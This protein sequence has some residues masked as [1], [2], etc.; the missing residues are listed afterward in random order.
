MSSVRPAQTPRA[1]RG[2]PL[3]GD[4]C[5]GNESLFPP[6]SSDLASH[7]TTAAPLV[8]SVAAASLPLSPP[9]SFLPPPL[10]ALCMFSVVQAHALWP[11][12]S[13]WST[14]GCAHPVLTRLHAGLEVLCM[15]GFVTVAGLQDLGPAT[16]PGGGSAAAWDRRARGHVA[17]ACKLALA[18]ALAS[19]AADAVAAAYA[20]GGTDCTGSSMGK[21]LW[22]LPFLAA[23]RLLQ[24]LAC[25]LRLD[26]AQTA[27]AWALAHVLLWGRPAL[28]PPLGTLDYLLDDCKLR[29]YGLFYFSLAPA[30]HAAGLPSA[31]DRPRRRAAALALG[32]A[33]L[34]AIP[35]LAPRWFDDGFQVLSEPRVPLGL[36]A[37]QAAAAALLVALALEAS[38]RRPSPVSRVL[39]AGTFS[40]FLLH[41][42]LRPIWLSALK[43]SL[44]ALHAALPSCAAP[45][46]LGGL[47]PAA[48]L[49]SAHLGLLLAVQ[50]ALS[51]VAVDLGPPGEPWLAH[52][53]RPLAKSLAKLAFQAAA[54]AALYRTAPRDA[55]LGHRCAAV[56]FHP[57]LTAVF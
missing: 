32:L 2:A 42:W 48:L 39:G 22:Y 1:R 34:V 25:L 47:G 43:A 12:L 46:P 23:C 14:L 41:W 50:W 35:A 5:G 6:L 56:V 4:L 15:P 8:C 40:C 24:G 55:Y 28:G 21:V 45:G 18:F 53:A 54:W 26:K 20:A 27:A 30:L 57:P 33:L 9:L 19:R 11:R 29:T 3:V 38:P 51:G 16:V 49:A 10:A 17:S 44:E 36:H 52:R 7:S 31:A 37:Q 13:F